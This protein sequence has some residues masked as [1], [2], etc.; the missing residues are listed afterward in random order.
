MCEYSMIV[1]HENKLKLNAYLWY[2]T[3]VHAVIINFKYIFLI[4]VPT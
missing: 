2:V 1:H 4:I 3:C